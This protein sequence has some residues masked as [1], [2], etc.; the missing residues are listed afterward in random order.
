MWVGTHET[1]SGLPTSLYCPFV[2]HESLAADLAWKLGDARRGAG[3]QLLQVSC[4]RLQQPK[5]RKLARGA[6]SEAPCLNH[7]RAVASKLLLLLTLPGLLSAPHVV[8]PDPLSS[9]YEVRKERA[10]KSSSDGVCN[11]GLSFVRPSDQAAPPVGSP[12]HRGCRV[13]P[14]A[15]VLLVASSCLT[16]WLTH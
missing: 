5:G 8:L 14:P 13:G 6:G 16:W 10:V 9:L 11:P 7:Q 12:L 2:R 3:S 15:V 1:A 4:L